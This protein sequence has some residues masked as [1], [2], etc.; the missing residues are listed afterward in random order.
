MWGTELYGV[1]I[2]LFSRLCL[3]AFPC[4]HGLAKHI[5]H[6]PS[7]RLYIAVELQVPI[8]SQDRNA[9]SP[10]PTHSA[11]DALFNEVGKYTQHKLWIRRAMDTD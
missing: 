11:E 7:F 4:K 8:K 2:S 10:R 6:Q 3:G 1:F 9:F 5:T